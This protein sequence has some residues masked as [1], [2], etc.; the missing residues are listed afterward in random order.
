MSAICVPQVFQFRLDGLLIHSRRGKIC[1]GGEGYSGLIDGCCK[2]TPGNKHSNLSVS[3]F[4][5]RIVP[6]KSKCSRLIS[7]SKH[8]SPE[9]LRYLPSFVAREAGERS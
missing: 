5:P 9:A 7:I 3:D 2:L 8:L 6:A 4:R 1:R